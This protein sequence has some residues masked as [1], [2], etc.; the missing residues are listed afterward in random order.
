M[1]R[2]TI[3]REA[4]KELKVLPKQMVVKITAAIGTL[5]DN[6]R[7]EG[8]KKLKGYDGNHWRIRVGDYRVIYSIDDTI[9]IV[10]VRHI[11]NR[12]DVYD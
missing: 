2:I 4:L 7:P 6:P 10:D 11:G 3:K 12:K 9:K 8:C 1:Y 5:S